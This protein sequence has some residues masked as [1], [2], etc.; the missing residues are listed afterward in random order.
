M[1]DSFLLYYNVINNFLLIAK[2]HTDSSCRLRL[3]GD[4]RKGDKK[5]IFRLAQG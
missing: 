4:R 3:A 5:N 2:G 1:Q